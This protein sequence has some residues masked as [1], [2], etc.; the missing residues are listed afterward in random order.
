MPQ[1]K[2]KLSEGEL[3]HYRNPKSEIRNGFVLFFIGERSR[4]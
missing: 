3:G 4:P 1:P 2:V